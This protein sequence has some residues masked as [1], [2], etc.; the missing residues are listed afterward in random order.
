MI[1]LS[2][3]WTTMHR[4]FV[5]T[6]SGIVHRLSRSVQNLDKISQHKTPKSPK[7]KKYDCTNPKEK[8]VFWQRFA[9][10]LEVKLE[11]DQQLG[12]DDAYENPRLTT[13][14][15]ALTVLEMRLVSLVQNQQHLRIIQVL[16][17]LSKCDC[18]TKDEKNK[19]K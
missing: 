9:D 18:T 2:I 17:G 11:N 3:A 1:C 7:D 16:K 14:L 10:H 12:D 19:A 5:A 4:R 13:N 6:T 8:D 15:L